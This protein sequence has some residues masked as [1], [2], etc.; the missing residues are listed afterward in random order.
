M[1]VAS[2]VADARRAVFGIRRALFEAGIQT[3]SPYPMI[4]GTPAELPNT[5]QLCE[6]L[7]LVPCHPSLEGPSLA[8]LVDGLDRALRRLES[9]A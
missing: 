1:L 9:V 7:L 2:D 6:R 5:A 4:L 8:G 3:E